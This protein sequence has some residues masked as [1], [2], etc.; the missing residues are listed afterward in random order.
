MSHNRNQVS[1][2]DIQ[3]DPVKCT[4]FILTRIVDFLHIFYMNQCPHKCSPFLFALLYVPVFNIPYFE[5]NHNAI[6]LAS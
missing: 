1:F 4:D 5:S 2:F 6:L 3:I